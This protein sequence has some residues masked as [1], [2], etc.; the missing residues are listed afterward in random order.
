MMHY[1]Y[2]N[3]Y[4]I[5]YFE[6]IIQIIVILFVY[7]GYIIYI[8]CNNKEN[9]Y[10]FDQVFFIKEIL[11][12]W[13][14]IPVF[15]LILVILKFLELRINEKF[16]PTYLVVAST[17]FIYYK[18][19]EV[20]SGN[21]KLTNNIQKIYY[22][23]YAIIPFFFCEIIILN[24]LGFGKNTRKIISERERRELK[25]LEEDIQN[26]ELSINLV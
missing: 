3:P 4:L 2:A 8:I 22:I 11:N 13:L 16:G 20:I 1:L 23:I 12:H 10:I 24:F 17:C 25:K 26:F 21:S 6:G 9:Q 5:I 15:F 14:I 18:F 7:S 19:Y